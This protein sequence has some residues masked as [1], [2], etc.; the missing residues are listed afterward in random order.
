M[1]FIFFLYL[2]VCFSSWGQTLYGT[3][4]IIPFTFYNHERQKF[5]IIE[6]STGCQE[7]NEQTKKWEFRK[8]EYQIE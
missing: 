8:L 5:T 4:N 6:D 2:L 1:R 7:Y 3:K